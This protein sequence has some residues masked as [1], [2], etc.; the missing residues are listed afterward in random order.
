MIKVLTWRKSFFIAESIIGSSEKYYEI[1]MFFAPFWG[2]NA[3]LSGFFAAIGRPGV[4]TAV[5]IFANSINICFDYVLIFGIGPFAALGLNG[6]AIATVMAQ[7]LQCGILFC[8][9]VSK[10]NQK[11]F[12]TRKFTWFYPDFKKSLQIG[13]P[14]ALSH[15]VE[16]AAWAILVGIL[17]NLSSEHLTL[18][19]IFQSVM[20][21]F[22]FINDG[23]KQ[24]VAVLAA[25]SLGSRKFNKIYKLL[26]LGILFQA[27]ICCFLF[28]PL[29]AF[30]EISISFLGD[31][32]LVPELLSQMKL[33]LVFS[34]FQ[35]C[36]L[37]NLAIFM[38]DYPIMFSS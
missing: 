30:P 17:S 35:S 22:G 9:F 34:H 4:V 5:A 11:D 23:L 19:S 21:L 16:I 15:G 28:V 29:V 37:I 27:I 13:I 32:A 12:C 14:N 1:L 33:G 26:K 10:K 3:D 2:V 7:L 20:L 8:F 25:N 31:F 38:E 6:A 18:F 36:F 24:G